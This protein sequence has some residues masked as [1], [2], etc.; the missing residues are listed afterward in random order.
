MA[1]FR[2]EALAEQ[3]TSATNYQCA[4]FLP[5][6]LQLHWVTAGMHDIDN[7]YTDIYADREEI[8]TFA[9]V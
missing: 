5:P 9:A 7:A 6:R 4:A 8:E 1:T 2:K 3:L